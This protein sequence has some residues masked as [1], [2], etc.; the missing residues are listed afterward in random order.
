[1]NRLAGNSGE[2][3][4]MMRAQQVRQRFKAAI[5]AVYRQA[6]PLFLRHVN[7]VYILNKNGV[8]NLV[9]YVDESIFAAELNAQRELLKYKMLEL[10]GEDLSDFKIC[11]SRGSYKKLHPYKDE[12]PKEDVQMPTDREITESQKSF[13]AKTVE[14]VEDDLLRSKLEKAMMAEIRQNN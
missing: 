5:E 14:V 2:A 3:R 12:A 13:V 4:K 8:K 7:S 11:V 9:V 6:S 10:F 1:M